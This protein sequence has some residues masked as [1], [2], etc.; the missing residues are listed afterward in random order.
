VVWVEERRSTKTQITTLQSSLSTHSQ[1][2]A[3]EQSEKNEMHAQI[4]K[5]ESHQAAQMASRDRL[6]SAISHT[7]R[8]IDA[9]LQAQREYAEKMDGQ[10]RLNAPELNFWETYLGC[11]IEGAGEDSKIRVVYAFPPAK[12]GTSEE[13]REAV[14]EL[15]VPAGGA[16][17][18]DVVHTKPRLDSGKVKKVVTRLNET[19]EISTLLKGMRALFTEEM[20]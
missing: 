18:Y 19:R 6:R 5:L 20:K 12:G 4:A 7:Q 13:D 9:K 11:R 14:F 15:H 17:W 10:S 3:R 2:L 1:I 16:D 8:Q